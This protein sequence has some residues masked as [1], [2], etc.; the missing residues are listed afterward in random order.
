[1]NRLGKNAG[2][3]IDFVSGFMDILAGIGEA[4]THSGLVFQ[5]PGWDSRPRHLNMKLEEYLLLK[6]Q[7]VFQ[8]AGMRGKE[9]TARMAPA[10]LSLCGF[11]KKHK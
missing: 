8:R 1:M 9:M 3:C 7:C 10:P 11:R 4:D 5:K 6:F 2:N